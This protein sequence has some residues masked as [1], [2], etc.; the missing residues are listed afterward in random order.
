M[1]NKLSN[2]HNINFYILYLRAPIMYRFSEIFEYRPRPSLLIVSVTLRLSV[3][4]LI[5][6][7]GEP[8]ESGSCSGD[9]ASPQNFYS[10]KEEEEEEKTPIIRLVDVISHQNGWFFKLFQRAFDPPFGNISII[11]NLEIVRMHK[12]IGLA[13]PNKG[14]GASQCL[15]AEFY[16]MIIN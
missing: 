15:L 8:N 3:N 1:S 10:T 11:K 5:V 16:Q 2:C 7:K 13:Q 12:K 9:I 4:M 14:W 6:W